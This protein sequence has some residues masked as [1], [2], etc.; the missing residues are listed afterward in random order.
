MRYSLTVIVAIS[1]CA[2]VGGNAIG[3]GTR[4]SPERASFSVRFKDVIS[5][6]RRFSVFVEP[7]EQLALEIIRPSDKSRFRLEASAGDLVQAGKLRWS[8]TAP[9]DKGRYAL[10]IS[11]EETAEVM[12]LNA[13]VIVP[14]SALKGEYLNNYRVGA[15]PAIPYRNLPAYKPPAGFVEVTDDNADTL[16]SPHFTLKQFLCKQKG[17]YPKYMVLLE[18][19]LLKLEFILEKTNEQGISCR[20]FTVMSGY[21][22]PYY[23]RKIGNVKY[24]RHMW[25]GAADIFVDESPKDGM[26]D[27]LNKDGVIDYRDA[28]VL[29]DIIDGLYGKRFYAPFIGGLG[30][31][32]KTSDHGPFVH[33]DVRGFRARW[34]EKKME[35]TL[36]DVIDYGEME[37]EEKRLESVE[38]SIP[39][40]DS[41]SVT[42]INISGIHDV[43]I[44]Q[45][46]GEHYALH[47][48]TLEDIVNTHHRPK[49]EDMGDYVFVVIKMLYKGDED[50]NL[51][52]EQISIVFGKNYVITFQ[53]AEGD[54][55]ECVRKRIKRTVP[56][57]RFL[58]SDYLAYALMDAIV[59]N[60]FLVLEGVGEMV[61][62][63]EDELVQSPD[64]SDLENIHALKRELLFMRKAV[65]PL[66]EIIGGLERLDSALIH[67]FTRPY[68]RDLYEHT[69]QVIDTVETFRDMVSGLLDIYL[70]SLSNKMNEIM[71]VLTIIATIFIPLGFLAGV[72]GMNFDPPLIP[73]SLLMLCLYITKKKGGQCRIRPN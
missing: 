51:N 71:K 34:G 13:F 36:I 39:F 11:D 42:W 9:T 27:D 4:Y 48:L 44:M 19:L 35:K 1:L 70:S 40:K 54:V 32:K 25:G 45:K 58:G 10:K 43:A 73:A 60:Y 20:T 49:M 52:A 26:M 41:P 7:S 47:P 68:M 65:W 64:P 5:P 63:L 46:L 15:Y 6:Y 29:Y 38:E 69:I 72:Y 17:E 28:S 23:N 30:R 57:V 59:D 53:E 50:D 66:R 61:E 8:W 31:Y 37:Y 55:F 67:D 2:L 3:S 14:Y 24:S 12:E 62:G 33:V 21:R 56:R 18:K 22:T 16:V